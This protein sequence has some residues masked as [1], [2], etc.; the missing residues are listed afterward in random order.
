MKTLRLRQLLSAT[1]ILAF[2]LLWDNV[3]SVD[4]AAPVNN[5]GNSSQNQR[6][7]PPDR[8]PPGTKDNMLSCLG[9]EVTRSQRKYKLECDATGYRVRRYFPS[10]HTVKAGLTDCY[11]SFTLLLECYY[12]S[13][14]GWQR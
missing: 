6:P 1:A 7:P 9:N 10:T 13:I 14:S 3:S 8:R 2:S 12:G 11:V 5:N 4:L